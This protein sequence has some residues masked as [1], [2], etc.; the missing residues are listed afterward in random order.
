M[1]LKL[2][3]RLGRVALLKLRN[4]HIDTG[5]IDRIVREIYDA[6]PQ[7]ED[8]TGK[9]R[10]SVFNDKIDWSSYEIER[11]KSGE[12]PKGRTKLDCFNRATQIRKRGGECEY[13]T[14]KPKWSTKEVNMLIN[15]FCPDGRSKGACFNKATN[16]RATGVVVKYG[17][18]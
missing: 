10:K 9:P 5:N 13:F 11:L 1:S 12:I 14:V 17:E 4:T 3:T 7:S 2:Y 18:Q 15:G 16:I 8:E 6:C